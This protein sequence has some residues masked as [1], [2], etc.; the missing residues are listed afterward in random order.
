MK[1]SLNQIIVNPLALRL[2]KI[3][4]RVQQVA[5]PLINRKKEAGNRLT[6]NGNRS[7]FSKHSPICVCRNNGRHLSFDDTD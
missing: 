3:I 6:P 2:K 1:K 4:L 5:K 7:N